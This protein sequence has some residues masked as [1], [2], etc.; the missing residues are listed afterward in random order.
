MGPSLGSGG[1]DFRV[2]TFQESSGLT[3]VP[4]GLLNEKVSLAYTGFPALPTFS[5]TIDY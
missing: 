3:R 1:S 2:K 5:R 4:L